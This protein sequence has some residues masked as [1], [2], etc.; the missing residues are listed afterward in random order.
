MKKL[1]LVVFAA[2]VLAIG[3]VAVTGAGAQEGTPTPAR[4]FANLLDRVAEKLGVSHDQL[5][6]AFTDAETELID[7]AVA[8]GRLTEEQG[9][10]LKERI[11]EYGPFPPPMLRHHGRCHG[12]RPVVQAAAQVLD[13][14][15]QAVIDQLKGGKSLAEI[16]QAQGMSVDR[17]TA[18]LADAVHTKLNDK[19]SAGELTQERADEILQKFSENVDEIVNHHLGDADGPPCLRGPHGGGQGEEEPAPSNSPSPTPSA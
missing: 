7:E 11:Q 3:V 6:T 12:A 15:P 13:L 1:L 2:L 5:T 9:D 10:R 17:F 8:D 4:P 19:V 18:A 14:E 16:A